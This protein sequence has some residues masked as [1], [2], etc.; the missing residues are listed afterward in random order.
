MLAK[1]RGEIFRVAKPG[2]PGSHLRPD[3]PRERAAF[4]HFP[5]RKPEV[6]DL[7]YAQRERTCLEYC[8]QMPGAER[9]VLDAGD[10]ALYRNSLWHI[11]NYVPYRKRA[12]LHDSVRTPEYDAFMDRIDQLNREKKAAQADRTPVAAPQAV[13]R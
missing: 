8:R 13:S 3:L 1:D 10:F 4:P 5:P 2:Q 12:T 7:G 11:G 9:L 6:D